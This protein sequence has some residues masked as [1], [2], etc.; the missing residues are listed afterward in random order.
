[1]PEYPC[2]FYNHLRTTPISG[3]KIWV[4]PGFKVKN[5][6][7]CEW[8]GVCVK[9]AHV[10][11]A[12]VKYSNIVISRGSTEPNQKYIFTWSRKSLSGS[13]FLGVRKSSAAFGWIG[14]FS[15]RIEIANGPMFSSVPNQFWWSEKAT[16]GCQHLTEI[17]GCNANASIRSVFGV[18]MV[19]NLF[20]NYQKKDVRN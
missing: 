17:C 15:R 12:V 20:K 14:T 4:R 16:V 3:F 8:V 11:S 13:R 5:K 10:I 6:I 19:S 7:M 1:L 18:F 9:L 2:Q